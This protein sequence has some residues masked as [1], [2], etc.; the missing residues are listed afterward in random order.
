MIF[1]NLHRHPPPSSTQPQLSLEGVN[2]RFRRLLHGRSICAAITRNGVLDVCPCF[3]CLAD[4]KA[5]LGATSADPPRVRSL[6]A[7]FHCDPLPIHSVWMQLLAPSA[8]WADIDVRRG[9][10]SEALSLL[11]AFPV[12]ETAGLRFCD[13][14]CS[15]P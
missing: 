7:V 11:E 12:L 6:R 8:V 1:L 14:E 10:M 3:F 2:R 13:Y 15:F 4:N 9:G 5:W